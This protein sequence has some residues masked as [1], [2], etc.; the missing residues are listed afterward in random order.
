MKA[1]FFGVAMF[2]LGMAGHHLMSNE[3]I[4]KESQKVAQDVSKRAQDVKQDVK[5]RF[6]TEEERLDAFEECLNTLK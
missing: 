4:Q 6:E 5:R 1:F 3:E 2:A